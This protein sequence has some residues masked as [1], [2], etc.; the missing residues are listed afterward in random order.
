[1]DDPG[2]LHEAEKILKH[3]AGQHFLDKQVKLQVTFDLSV[4][5]WHLSLEFSQ[6]TGLDVTKTFK[7][8]FSGNYRI[9][10][11]DLNKLR[12]A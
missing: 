11:K 9:K 12:F 5:S 3:L 6:I 10:E 4:I 7:I 1:V 2:S 8:I